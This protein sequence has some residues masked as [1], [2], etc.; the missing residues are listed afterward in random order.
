[1]DKENM[2]EDIDE[3]EYPEPL[4]TMTEGERMIMRALY[5]TNVNLIALIGALKAPGPDQEQYTAN[6]LNNFTGAVFDVGFDPLGLG[7]QADVLMNAYFILHEEQI[8]ER[9]ENEGSEY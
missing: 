4:K 5:V 8:R 2:T 7:E 6:L 3:R 9:R 1:M